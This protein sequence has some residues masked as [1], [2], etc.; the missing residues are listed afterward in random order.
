MFLVRADRRSIP[1][2]MNAIAERHSQLPT[3]LVILADIGAKDAKA[4]LRAFADDP[5]P[6]VA[7][8]ARDGLSTIA[9]KEKLDRGHSPFTPDGP[10]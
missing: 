10:A 8:A 7:R 4:T 9:M 1:E 2:L 5:D 3:Y 6:A